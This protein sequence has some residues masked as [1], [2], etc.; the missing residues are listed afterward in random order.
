MWKR[1]FVFSFCGLFLALA[2]IA[3]GPD[4]TIT[5]QGKKPSQVL[6]QVE[7]Q[8]VKL[9]G[10]FDSDVSDGKAQLYEWESRAEKLRQFT[11]DRVAGLNIA[12]WKGDELLALATL[13]QQAELFAQAASSYRAYLAGGPKDRD[14]ENARVALTRA[15]LE[16]GQLEEAQKLL[17][18]RFRQMPNDELRLIS[19]VALHKDLTVAWRDRGKYGEV[20]KEAR[21]GYDLADNNE[22]FRRMDPRLRETVDRDQMTMAAS[23]IAAQEKTGFK[24]EAEEFNQRVLKRDFDHQPGLKSFYEAEMITARLLGNSAPELVTARWLGNQSETAPKTFADLRG[25]VILLDF[26]AM[27]CSPCVGAFPHL[28][29]FQTKYAGKGFEVI[30]VTRFYGRSDSEEDLS[31]EQEWKSLQ[32]FKGKHK[33]GYSIAVGKLDDPTNDDRYGIAGLPTV[34][35]IDRRGNVR[36]IK[37]GAGE[38][39]K[40]EKQI[41]TLVNEN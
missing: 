39:R 25:K 26:W 9:L 34:I 18:E 31:R 30:G 19:S 16:N 8:Q 11:A 29:E 7:E 28:R 14:A 1:V 24:K 38:Y 15:L 17:D 13:Y 27:W 37:R 41:E 35:L 10:S 12:D 22:K 3:F 33:L 23:L 2:Q 40:L 5:A 32:N 4:S 36:Q 21:R 6:R 20:I